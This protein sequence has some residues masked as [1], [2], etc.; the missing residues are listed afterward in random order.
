MFLEVLILSLLLYSAMAVQKHFVWCAFMRPDTSSCALNHI[1]FRAGTVLSHA[2]V[3]CTG[4]VRALMSLQPLCIT[5]EKNSI[6]HIWDIS[7]FLPLNFVGS[8]IKFI[9]YS[10]FPG[11]FLSKHLVV[12]RMKCFADNYLFVDHRLRHNSRMKSIDIY[13]CFHYN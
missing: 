12:K 8:L 2:F 4:L 9:S 3:W 6:L 11:V 1:F 7:T 13:F 10:N 5:L